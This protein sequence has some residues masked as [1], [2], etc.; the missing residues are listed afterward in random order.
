MVSLMAVDKGGEKRKRAVSAER[1]A[2]V[3]NG[4]D[5]SSI[6]TSDLSTP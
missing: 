1:A 6:L 4:G 3:Q 5:K 2:W